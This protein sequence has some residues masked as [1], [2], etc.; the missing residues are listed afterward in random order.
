MS[1][2][3]CIKPKKEE[4]RGDI[5]ILCNGELEVKTKKERKKKNE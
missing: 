5:H 1:K 4:I 3:Y 2:C